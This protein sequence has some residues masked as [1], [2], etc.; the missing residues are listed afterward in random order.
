MEQLLKNGALDVF[1]T[2]IF[3]KKNRPAYR[4][5][6]IC[7]E[8]DLAK[9]QNIIF[10]ETTTIGVRYYRV[11]RTELLREKVELETKYGKITA[12]KVITPN[13]EIFVYPEYDSAKEIA[14]ESGIPLKDIYKLVGEYCEKGNKRT[15]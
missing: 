12:K 11:D 7:K 2:S 10:K 13:G 9:L 4:L 14:E 5:E 6:V 1:Y 8:Q 15:N 3:M